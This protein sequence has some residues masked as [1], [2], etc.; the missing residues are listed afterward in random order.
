[1][2]I[3]ANAGGAFDAK[4]YDEHP[5]RYISVFAKK[6]APYASV[7]INGIY[8][9]PDSPKLITIPDAKVLLRSSHSHLPWVQ[10]KSSTSNGPSFVTVTLPDLLLGY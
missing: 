1:M 6:I 2:T 8:W 10:V 5:H 4:E 9:A 7:I 3:G